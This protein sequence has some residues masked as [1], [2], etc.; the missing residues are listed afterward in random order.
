[1]T[2]IKSDIEKC[3][4]EISCFQSNIIAK[5]MILNNLIDYVRNDFSCNVFCDFDFKHRCL[6]R[7]INM[8][9]HIIGIQKFEIHRA[10]FNV[11][12]LVY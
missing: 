1:M 6:K 5:A 12:I 2:G 4:K 8:N 7:L 3:R 9:K 11:I 10:I